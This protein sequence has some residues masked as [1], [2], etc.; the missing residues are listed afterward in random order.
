MT[1]SIIRNRY[2]CILIQVSFKVKTVIKVTHNLKVISLHVFHYTE[3]PGECQ[4]STMLADIFQHIYKSHDETAHCP[5]Y[6]LVSWDCQQRTDVVCE[7]CRQNTAHGRHDGGC[8]AR[9]QG[10]RSGSRHR[11]K[12]PSQKGWTRFTHGS[13]P[14]TLPLRYPSAGEL[15][16]PS[17]DTTPMPGLAALQRVWPRP[18]WMM[19]K[20]GRRTFRPHTPLCTMWSSERK[21]AKA[22]QLLSRW[23]PQE[24]VWH[25]GSWPA[26]TS[27]KRSLRH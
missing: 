26:W 24:E 10:L 3:L 8:R 4:W 7:E 18:C 1:L 2:I 23:R 25:G 11:S 6:T 17:L 16:S 19:T 27:A 20:T 15:F 21:V 9:G 14:N 22:N 12:T 13:P 5:P